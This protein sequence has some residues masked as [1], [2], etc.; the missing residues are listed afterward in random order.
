MFDCP[1]KISQ[2]NKKVNKTHGTSIGHF[3][4]VFGGQT[5]VFLR[6]ISLLV[7]NILV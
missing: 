3:F 6:R 5:K 2:S 4:G 1:R 7:G